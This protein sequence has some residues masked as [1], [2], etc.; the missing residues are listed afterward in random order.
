MYIAVG[1]YVDHLSEF[2]T[3]LN[4]LASACNVLFKNPVIS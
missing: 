2:L 1:V 3:V 4:L